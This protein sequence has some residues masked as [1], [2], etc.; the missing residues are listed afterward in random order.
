M[1]DEVFKYKI[2]QEVY[3]AS[4]FKK[5]PPRFVVTYRGLID[6]G[7]F[8]LEKHY[9][10]RQLFEHIEYERREGI[11]IEPIRLLE[12]EISEFPKVES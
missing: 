5:K 4:I 7:D 12:H 1:L 9:G 11:S 8:C 2:G 10:L 6:R 3:Y